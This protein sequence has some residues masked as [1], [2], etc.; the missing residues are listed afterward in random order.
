MNRQLG[1]VDD[2]FAAPSNFSYELFVETNFRNCRGVRSRHVTPSRS[3][4]AHLW[5]DNGNADFAPVSH[6]QC[7][8]IYASPSTTVIAGTSGAI[9]QRHSYLSS[10]RRITRCL[11][12]DIGRHKPVPSDVVPHG[13]HVTSYAVKIARDGDSDRAA[14]LFTAAPSPGKLHP[15]TAR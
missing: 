6:R 3:P 14:N 1:D 12:S 11:P 8:E 10:R 4:C 13:L 9:K 2:Y 5:S 15:L 7:G